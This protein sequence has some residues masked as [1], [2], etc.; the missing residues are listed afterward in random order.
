MVM[1]CN[2][3][4]AMIVAI[5]A[6][7]GEGCG[8][9]KCANVSCGQFEACD[10]TDG[11]CKCGGRQGGDGGVSGVVCVSGE[12]CSGILQQCVSDLCANVNCSNGN[13]CTPSDGM[14]RC[15]GVIC[16]A[17]SLC[18]QTLHQ[19]SSVLPCQDVLCPGGES[20]DPTTGTCACG[21]SASCGGGQS[22]IDGGCV[23]DPCFGLHCSGAGMACYAGVCRCGGSTGPSC[24]QDELCQGNACVLSARCLDVSCAPGNVCSPADGLCHCAVV[25][26][27]I[28][29]G[30]STCTLYF[31][32]SGLPTPDGAKYPDSGMLGYCMGGNLCDS[33]NGGRGCLNP[34]ESCN[35]AT[36]Y[37]HCGTIRDAGALPPM[38]NPPNTSGVNFCASI[39]GGASPQCF[40][41]CDPY[42]QNCPTLAPPDGGADGGA[43]DASLLQA[44]YYEPFL[45]ALVCEAVTKLDSYESFECTKNSDCAPQPNGGL[46]CFELTGDE[47][48]S[49]FVRACRYFC[50]NFDGGQHLCPG[51]GK[52]GSPVRQCVPISIVTDDAGTSTAVG[53]CQPYADGG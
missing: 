5:T 11:Q 36:G 16:G 47:L 53:A 38:C 40:Q 49:G 50:D 4:A 27:P 15:G 17:D 26:G 35:P 24:N 52:G 23:G 45:N 25:D 48:D 9:G 33:V 43:P 7:L 28:C 6:C 20:C 13:S 51:V 30:H 41:P 39:D 2:V 44:C 10:P 18:D 31:A 29:Q 34:L 46:D 32:A 42:A 12:T 19:C 21:G 22:C 3:I 8:N 14:C 37:C 1:K